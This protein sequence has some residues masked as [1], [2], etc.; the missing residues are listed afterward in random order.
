MNVDNP[1]YEPLES[2][3]MSKDE[4]RK[5]KAREYAEKNKDKLKI[6]RLEKLIAELREENKTLKENNNPYVL[7]PD[8]FE[9]L[10]KSE[11]ELKEKVEQLEETNRA[12]I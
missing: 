3:V 9:A 10:V 12:L 7:V 8:D 2:G 5:L 6:K 4:I 1:Q 11:K